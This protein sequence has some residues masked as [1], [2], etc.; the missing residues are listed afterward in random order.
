MSAAAWFAAFWVVF[1]FFLQKLDAGWDQMLIAAL[2]ILMLMCLFMM[3]NDIIV[4]ATDGDDDLVRIVG[5][6]I[7]GRRW[8]Y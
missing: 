4:D 8:P 1:W 6:K 3:V 7:G 5:R 2:I